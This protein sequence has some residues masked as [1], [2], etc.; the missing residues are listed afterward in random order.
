MKG[1]PHPQADETGYFIAELWLAH[2]V[3]NCFPSENG[4]KHRAVERTIHQDSTLSR[5]CPPDK[6]LDGFS[7]FVRNPR[8]GR[9]KFR[10][11]PGE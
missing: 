6:D 11:K 7:D 4:L 8:F 1:S 9:N 3:F 2:F 10:R 5:A